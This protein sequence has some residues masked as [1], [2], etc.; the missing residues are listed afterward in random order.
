[1]VFALPLNGSNGGTTFTDLHATIKGSGSAKSVEVTGNT[2]TSTTQS[3]YYGSSGYFDGTGDYLTLLDS[4]DFAFGSGDFTIE[5]WI[6]I[7][8]LSGSRTI[9]GQAN[10]GG[11][12]AS[13]GHFLEVLSDGR[14]NGGGFNPGDNYIN[15]TTTTSDALVVNR[16]YHIAMVRNGND[17]NLH[18]NGV[19]KAT[20]S[21]SGNRLQYSSNSFAY[22]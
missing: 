9:S 15:V 19:I 11:G 21:V 1:M 16:W 13:Y 4:S 5:A 17:L 6:Y 7:T 22:R 20:S 10:S 14:V 8:D 12:G 18:I 3:K 2:Q